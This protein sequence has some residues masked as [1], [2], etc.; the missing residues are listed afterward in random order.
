MNKKNVLLLVTVVVLGAAYVYFF[1]DWFRPKHIEIFHTSRAVPGGRLGA[2]V[3]AGNANTAVVQ[4]GLDNT[5]RLTEITVL[6]LDELKTNPTALPMWHLISDS[7]SVPIKNFP[8]GVAVAGMK[9]AVGNEWPQPL[10][11][12]VHYRIVVAAGSRTGQHDFL[13]LPKS[14]REIAAEAAATAARPPGRP[15]RVR[16]NGVRPETVRTNQPG[17]SAN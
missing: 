4:F 1:T 12:N 11:P 17:R 6:S 5:Y 13:T 3:R 16:P 7:N 8:Y 2:R 14:E 10:D 9:P 15:D